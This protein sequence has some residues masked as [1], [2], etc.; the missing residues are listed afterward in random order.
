LGQ[1][2]VG[3]ERLQRGGEQA[4]HQPPPVSSS[5]WAADASRSGAAERYQ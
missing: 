5:R 4:H 2:P 1:Q 3:E